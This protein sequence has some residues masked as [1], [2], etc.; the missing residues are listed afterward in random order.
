MSTSVAPDYFIYRAGHGRR[1]SLDPLPEIAR[2]RINPYLVGVLP[3][4]G[5]TDFVLAA[6][7]RESGQYKLD[8]FRSKQRD[9]TTELL[10][11]DLPSWMTQRRR[12]VFPSKVIALQGGFLG[13][14]DL[15][16]GILLCNVL[17]SPVCVR[18]L[19]LPK[20]LPSNQ[21]HYN[22]PVAWPIRDVTCLDGFIIRCVEL[23]DVY[24]SKNSIRDISTRDLY[25]DSEAVD[26]AE[27]VVEELD[28]WRLITWSREIS[29]DYWRK[30]SVSHA[31]ELR[32]L[33]LPH[34]DYGGNGA[35]ESPLRTFKA[36]YPSVCGDDIVCLMLKHNPLDHDAWILTVDMKSKTVGEQVPYNAKRSRHSNTT[37]IPCALNKYMNSESGNYCDTSY[38]TT[39][40]NVLILSLFGLYLC[41]IDVV[42]HISLQLYMVLI[43]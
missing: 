39:G 16:K 32:T 13:F 14:V 30:G 10:V 43:F 38:H 35:A 8:I 4:D 34:P 15:W 18:F 21:E 28:G 23:E 1:P 33:S 26:P 36:S 20:L 5:G 6:F 11:P 24:S 12:I 31:D 29:W 25:F 9:W 17:E 40:K 27:G 22:E 7:R 37:Y 41:S 19:P 2:W 42:W 3:V